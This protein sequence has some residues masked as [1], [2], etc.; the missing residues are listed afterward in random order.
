VLPVVVLVAAVAGLAVA[1]R[2]WQR[3]PVLV[4][5]D[6]DREL[7]AAALADEHAEHDREP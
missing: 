1:F 2:K 4:P 5:S 3:E 6:E 7:V